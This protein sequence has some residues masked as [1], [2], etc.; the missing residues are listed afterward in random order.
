MSKKTLQTS[1]S[2]IHRVLGDSNFGPAKVTKDKS[3]AT[4]TEHKWIGPS[5]AKAA[6]PAAKKVKALSRGRDRDLTGKKRDKDYSRASAS[7]LEDAQGAHMEAMHGRG[8]K[9]AEKAYKSIGKEVG[10]R[11]KLKSLRLKKQG[12]KLSAPEPAPATMRSSALAA[13]VAKGKAKAPDTSAIDKGWDKVPR[14]MA[15]REDKLASR[16]AGSQKVAALRSKDSGGGPKTMPSGP[17]TIAGMGP[18]SMSGPKTMRDKSVGKR[19]A[20]D[21]AR[22]A[23]AARA[24][25]PKGLDALK[26]RLGTPKPMPNAAPVAAAKAE[27]K[28]PRPGM[29]MVGVKANRAAGFEKAM[30]KK[31][32]AKAAA[33]AAKK[34]AKASAPPVSVKPSRA[35]HAKAKALI[36]KR[37]AKGAA[38]MARSLKHTGTGKALRAQLDKQIAAKAKSAPKKAAPAKSMMTGRRGGQYYIG[39]NGA[40]I[41]VGKGGKGKGKKK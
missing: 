18:A 28:T 13:V 34:T 6:V 8:A 39:A 33:P 12:G 24:A 3:G 7:K 38:A 11:N 25:K 31:A 37:G 1:S 22:E 30:A 32:A 26:A 14:P 9:A 41:Y 20:L 4:V 29:K 5:P 10:L 40:K 16:A 19:A 21:K 2:D 15:T 36:G 35:D 23:K 27:K 17:P